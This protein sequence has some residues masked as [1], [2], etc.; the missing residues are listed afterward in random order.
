MKQ[1]HPQINQP[2]DSKSGNGQ[3][4]WE[5]E[6]I[7]NA[8]GAQARVQEEGKSVRHG[9]HVGQSHELGIRLWPK[10]RVGRIGPE[11]SYTPQP[12]VPGTA[13]SPGKKVNSMFGWQPTPPR[14]AASHFPLWNLTSACDGTRLWPEGACFLLSS[15]LYSLLETRCG[16]RTHKCPR[17]P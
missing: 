14:V 4:G 3:T 5:A 7:Q 9:L 13:E 11:G 15:R 8:M 16:W 10:G 12:A 1:G 17:D 2:R 6:W